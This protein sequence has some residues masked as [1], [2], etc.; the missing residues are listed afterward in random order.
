MFVGLM[1]LVFSRD[2]SRMSAAEREI[3]QRVKSLMGPFEAFFSP[4][5]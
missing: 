5:S 3:E 4:Q 2:E 1:P